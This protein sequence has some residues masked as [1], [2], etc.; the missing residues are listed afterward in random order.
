VEVNVESSQHLRIDLVM[1]QGDSVRGVLEPYISPDCNCTVSTTFFGAV[2]G[3]AITG[4]F[5]TRN[6]SEV[7]AAG[8]WEL[9]RVGDATR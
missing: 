1:A 4:R 6:R 3:D 7:R 8:S 5:E 9:K 2:K